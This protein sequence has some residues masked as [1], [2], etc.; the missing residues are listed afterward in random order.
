MREGTEH[1]GFFPRPAARHLGL[2]PPAFSEIP[3]LRFPW[4]HLLFK[5]VGELPQE[6]CEVAGFILP[7]LRTKGAS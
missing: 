5:V 7:V 4:I 6:V 3:G 2:M 1:S